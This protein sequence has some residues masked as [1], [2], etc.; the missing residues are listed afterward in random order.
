[1]RKD[2]QAIYTVEIPVTFKFKASD[3]LSS[4]ELIYAMKK[5][6]QSVIRNKEYTFLNNRA[7]IVDKKTIYTL[8]E[9]LEQEQMWKAIFGGI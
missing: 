9:K 1:M 5:V 8:E 7:S 4:D 2:R 3:G 6:M